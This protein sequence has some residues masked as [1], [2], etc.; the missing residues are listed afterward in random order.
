MFS[1][2]FLRK[3]KFHLSFAG[4]LGRKSLYYPY[5]STHKSVYLKFRRLFD[6]NYEDWEPTTSFYLPDFNQTNSTHDVSKI[7]S[8]TE[9][10]FHT[11]PNVTTGDS[12]ST[13]NATPL[14][15]NFTANT[16]TTIA[17]DTLTTIKNVVN[18]TSK[19]TFVETTTEVNLT[20]VVTTITDVTNV[21]NI[22]SK[23][24]IATN[25]SVLNLNNATTTGLNEAEDLLKA[26]VSST[27]SPVTTLIVSTPTIA[28]YSPGTVSDSG[29][30]KYFWTS[31]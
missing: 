7:A 9:T 27:S 20:E 12:L 3:I 5:R 10:V 29:P 28:K 24:T 30:R 1:S 6:Y 4:I 13:I 19:N 15:D 17:K 18:I 14:K 8:V 2:L 31:L 23:E 26:L 21:T 16:N 11:V 25:I 22:V